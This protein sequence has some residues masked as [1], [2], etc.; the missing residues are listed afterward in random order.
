[1]SDIVKHA[2]NELRHAGLFDTK[3][4]DYNGMIGQAVMKLVRAHAEEGHSGYSHHVT[5]LV[6]NRVINFKLLTPTSSDPAEWMEV[7]TG[8]W[9]N[10]RQSSLFSPNGG[11]WWYD[12]DSRSRWERFKWWYSY[13]FLSVKAPPQPIE[14]KPSETNHE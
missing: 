9:Q 2:E 11:L 8:M 3:G 7:G 10:R 14:T 13:K 4:T 6:F 5:M 1:M 12:I